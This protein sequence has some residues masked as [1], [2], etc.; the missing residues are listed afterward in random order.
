MVD[1]KHL[2]YKETKKFIKAME[3]KSIQE[4][5]AIQK[6]HPQLY[7]NPYRDFKKTGEW[8]SWDDFLGKKT[9][10]P[11]G[12]KDSKVDLNTLFDSLKPIV[13]PAKNSNKYAD[14]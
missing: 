1:Q 2:N 5:T 12:L 9:E 4:Y 14:R 11:I 8:V 13:V 6:Y 7:Y 3:L 10:N